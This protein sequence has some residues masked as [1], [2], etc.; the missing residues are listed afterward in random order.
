QYLAGRVAVIVGGQ[1]V[2]EGPPSSLGGRN[3]AASV[4][5]FSVPPGRHELPVDLGPIQA[6]DGGSFQIHTEDPTR[7]LHELTGWAIRE[8][9]RLDGL[10]GSP[11]ALDGACL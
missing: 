5:R 8:G 3:N 7:T 6:G 9:I 10:E 11:P 2:A 4:V 1:I